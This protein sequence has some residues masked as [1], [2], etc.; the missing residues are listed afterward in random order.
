[1]SITQRLDLRQSQTLTMTPQLQQAIKLLQLS[2][3]ELSEYIAEE[4]EKNPLLEKDDKALGEHVDP[5]KESKSAGEHNEEVKISERAA[6]LEAETRENYMQKSEDTP[7]S[8]SEEGL[9]ADF[10]N[11]FTG[12][13]EAE[14]VGVTDNS[15]MVDYDPGSSMADG[16]KG[17]NLKFENPEFSLENTLPEQVDL[18]AHLIKQVQI[19]I[20]DLKEQ[21]ISTVLL[22]HLDESGYMR[23]DLDELTERLG[24]ERKKV[25]KVL[26]KLQHLD[27]TGIFARDLAECLALQLK[28]KDRFDPVM[29]KFIDN[30]G[31]LGSGEF[32]TLKD[33]CGVDDEDLQDMIK[34]I[35]ELDPKPAL[36]FD[37]LVVQT[38]VPDVLMKALPKSQ[39]GGWAVELNADTLPRVLV[40]KKYY[41]EVKQH[42]DNKEAKEFINEQLMAASWLVKALD[43][44]AQTILKVATEIIRK[45][46]GFFTY[47]I[48]YLKPLV[49]RDIAE[50][51]QMHESTVSRVTNNKFIGTP[52]GV[53]E[54]KYFFTSS[55]SGAEGSVNH[56][57][58]AVK[59]RI[60][61]LIDNEGLEKILSDDA[62]VELL[63]KDK[64]DIARRTVA[65]YREAL[66][67]PSS[68][69]RRKTKKNKINSPLE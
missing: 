42:A 19:S 17:G 22:D 10:D 65:K 34:E 45:Q 25:E 58:E 26:D 44:R 35:R 51:I 48:E 1:M 23:A 55:I 13:S 53:F 20:P 18:K 50:V 15:S 46:D 4:L 36:K 9:D 67:I 21:M 60:K 59:S 8:G 69:Q 41:A 43:Q 12:N 11:V 28:E 52:R 66:R 38:V 16:G 31:L 57:S 61:S 33:I 68:V 3:L 40:N 39:G 54:L 30:L 27:P 2:N 32:K 56:S 37:H 63:K 5:D 14:S 62:I 49:L 24:C 47:G 29:K 7:I 6:E 64:I